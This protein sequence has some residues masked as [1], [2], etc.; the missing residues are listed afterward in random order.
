M[1]GL[2]RAPFVI[3]T[4]ALLLGISQNVALAAPPASRVYLALGNSL[5]A[6]VGASDP[7]TTAYVPLLAAYFQ[8][9]QHGGMGTSTNL[10]ISGETTDTFI[11]G[12]QLAGA[13]NIIRD[14]DTDVRA[15][16]LDIGGNDLLGLT[17]FEPCRSTPT[18]PECRALVALQLAK[19][20]VNYRIILGSLQ[21]A[22]AL[23]PGKESL[24][25]MTYY[26]PFDG[27]GHLYESFGDEVLLG[28]D[29]SL[30]C[31]T[32]LGDPRTGLNDVIVCVGGAFGAK[33]A[34]VFPLFDGR[35]LVLTHIAA[36]DIHPNDAGYRV[37]AGAFVAVQ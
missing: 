29:L 26:N 12:G 33:V 35:A 25:V 21:A 34:D 28:T 18:S 15:V 2:M 30:S 27:T 17:F 24:T 8:M 6:G 13:L 36:G 19:V 7:Q 16:T 5:G 37:I 11:A 4:A 10:S 22:L 9:P 31:A 14:P 1:L 20:A 23:D 32:T 3:L